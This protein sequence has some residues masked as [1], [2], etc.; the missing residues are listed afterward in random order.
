MTRRSPRNLA[1]PVAAAEP[2]AGLQRQPLPTLLSDGRVPRHVAHTAYPGHTHQPP[3]VTTRSL[4]VHWLAGAL[5][6]PDTPMIRHTEQVNVAEI[7]LQYLRALLWPVTA[8][9]VVVMLRGALPDLLTRLRSVKVFGVEAEFRRRVVDDVSGLLTDAANSA[10]PRR[11]G[12]ESYRIAPANGFQFREGTREAPGSRQPVHAQIDW[13]I[14]SF[15]SDEPGA[16]NLSK[17]KADLL[18]I[19]RTAEAAYSH[20]G[21]S[22]RHETRSETE[23]AE[24]QETFDFLASVTGIDGWLKIISALDLLNSLEFRSTESRESAATIA[25]LAQAIDITAR[26]LA[27][28]SIAKIDSISEGSGERSEASS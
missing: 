24:L 10:P 1:D 19:G 14:P 17:L 7:V 5:L 22:R 13:D 8:I 12:S 15:R 25:I 27:W 20:T 3:D 18:R 23:R 21:D 16:T 11:P 26:E 28:K 2:P 4:R 6:P 9:V